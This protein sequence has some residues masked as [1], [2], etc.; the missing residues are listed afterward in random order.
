M[1]NPFPFP[2]QCVIMSAIASQIISL[3]IIY[4]T[5]Y[6]GGDQSKH[7]SSA[8]LAW[9]HRRTVNSLHKWP[10]T[11]KVFPFD[12]VIMPTQVLPY[13][14]AEVIDLPAF[15]GLFLSS[16]LAASLRYCHFSDVLSCYN[17]VIDYTV[18]FTAM[19]RHKCSPHDTLKLNK[20]TSYLSRVTHMWGGNWPCYNDGCGSG[21]SFPDGSTVHWLFHKDW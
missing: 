8:S 17:T 15:S 5:D 18:S 11:R 20:P 14:V 10:V 12:N 3:M 6:S 16:L 21:S 13:F 19:Q 7:Q 2:L 9:I 4:P 1:W